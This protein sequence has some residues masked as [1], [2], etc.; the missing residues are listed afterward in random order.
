M[1]RLK[2]IEKIRGHL[3][4]FS[5]CKTKSNM[6]KEGR[7]ALRLEQFSSRGNPTLKSKQMPNL[8]AFKLVHH[9]Y[10]VHLWQPSHK[11]NSKIDLKA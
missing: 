5:L 9:L 4:R 2:L 3:S 7:I 11:N 10:N 1:F 6:A 8:M